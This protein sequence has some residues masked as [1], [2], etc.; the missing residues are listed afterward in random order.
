MFGA[1]P[2]SVPQRDYFSSFAQNKQTKTKQNKTTKKKT[3]QWST[4]DFNSTTPF[5]GILLGI[6]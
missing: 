5:F 4:L 2:F 1:T 3:P 6:S